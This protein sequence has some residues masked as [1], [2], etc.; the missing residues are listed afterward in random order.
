MHDLLAQSLPSEQIFYSITAEFVDRLRSEIPEVRESQ[1]IVEPESRDT[2]AAVCLVA[3]TLALRDPN[4]VALIVG[5]DHII[6][7]SEKF[8]DALIRSFRA[9]ERNPEAMVLVGTKPLRPHTGLGYIRLGDKCKTDT[10]P[11]LYSVADFEE[12]PSSRT[13]ERYVLYGKHV[14]NTGYKAFSCT[15]F[16]VRVHAIAPQVHNA[17]SLVSATYPSLSDEARAAFS[18]IEKKSFEYLF[19][20]SVPFLVLKAEVIWHDIGDWKTVHGLKVKEKSEDRVVL[21][22]AK[23]S[24]VIGG[25]R[26]IALYGAEDIV[27]V[28]TDDALLIVNR[29]R[30]RNIKEVIEELKRRG[31]H[32]YL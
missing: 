21:L 3:S 1:I 24:V 13:A 30:A 12:K 8:T 18:S 10:D 15:P 28:D 32:D 19:G 22:D 26:V 27:V 6:E 29:N 7:T 14:W 17:C 16:L 20:T 25:K 5:A 2:G 23:N 31:L 4:A 9:A 11:D